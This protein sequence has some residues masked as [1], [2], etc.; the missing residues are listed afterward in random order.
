MMKSSLFAL[1]TLTLLLTSPAWAI[2]STQD[3]SDFDLADGVCDA[4]PGPATVCTLRAEIEQ[5]NATGPWT[6]TLTIPAGTYVLTQGEIDIVRALRLESSGSVTIDAGGAD[7][8]FHVHQT[9]AYVR[10]TDLTIRG[11]SAFVGGAILADIARFDLVGCTLRDNRATNDG[12]A[13]YAV[14]VLLVTDSQFHDNTAL[15]NGGAVAMAGGSNTLGIEGSTFSGNHAD[16]HGGGVYG[17]APGAGVD[18]VEDTHF[19]GNDSLRDGGAYWTGRA[20]IIASTF[21][22]NSA[23]GDGGAVLA[24]DRT[25]V[26]GSAMRSNEARGNGGALRGGADVIIEDTD[27]SEN[28]AAGEGGGIAL[29]DDASLDDVTLDYNRAGGLGGGL[30]VRGDA[31]LRNS[32]LSGNVGSHGGG[33]AFVRGHIQLDR[34]SVVANYAANNGYGSGAGLYFA[35]VQARLD[36]VSVFANETRRGGGIAVDHILE[37]KG[38]KLEATEVELEN[39]TIAGNGAGH[40]GGGILVRGRARLRAASTTISDNR[41]EQGGGVATGFGARIE[42]LDAIVSRNLGS[43]CMGTVASAGHTLLT[44]TWGCSYTQSA[45]NGDLTGAFAY[46][47]PYPSNLNA[48]PGRLTVALSS[49]SPAIDRGSSSCPSRDQRDSARYGNGCDMGA[50]EFYGELRPAKR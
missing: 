12:G 45:A 34:V 16:G 30:L 21:M 15:G 26:V 19:E 23:R 9:A 24:G 47:A 29:G 33:A 10:F 11:G 41:A 17:L 50:R 18:W 7:R 27:A 42:L 3:R 39:C 35:Y 1:A 46:L 37:V 44:Q 13:V 2:N 8:A 38:E 49:A 28:R 48:T 4:D 22:E 31:R 36:R 5:F 20:E 6:G 43:D 32:S 40:S 25:H 14:G